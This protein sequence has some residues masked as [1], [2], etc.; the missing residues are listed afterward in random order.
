[1][2]CGE[3]VQV[4]AASQCHQLCPLEPA[5]TGLGLLLRVPSERHYDVERKTAVCWSNGQRAAF[6]SQ[7]SI[8]IQ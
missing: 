4:K 3:K 6:Q 7:T 1:M 5:G 8:H 2:R